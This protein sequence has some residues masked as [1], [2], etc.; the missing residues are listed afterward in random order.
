MKVQ[1]E[2]N[3][4]LQ[5]KMEQND[6]FRV[7]Y[8]LLIK[9]NQ[10]KDE[11]IKNMLLDIEKSTDKLVKANREIMQLEEKL[12]ISTNECQKMS[13]K[14]EENNRVIDDMLTQINHLKRKYM[15]A[16]SDLEN[17]QKKSARAQVLNDTK[18][19]NL[20][21]QNIRQKQKIHDLQKKLEAAI[22]DAKDSAMYKCGMKDGK[23][24]VESSVPPITPNASPK[25]DALALPLVKS[26]K[27]SSTSSLSPQQNSVKSDMILKDLEVLLNGSGDHGQKLY[28]E[29]KT[30]LNRKNEKIIKLKAEQIK[31][32]E[33]IKQMIESRNKANE[34]IQYLKFKCTE[35]ETELESVATKQEKSVQIDGN[36]TANNMNEVEILDKLRSRFG[37]FHFPR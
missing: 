25:K 37:R 23:T 22:S 26:P 30:D 10:L 1:K 34:E 5:S 28:C 6:S 17:E 15:C 18:I 13:E 4:S 11:R 16:K 7:K 35:F 31:A 24:D 21:E 19:A 8:E 36:A 9:E 29:L 3:A 33:I 2:N 27:N 14:V 20:E 12:E 32:C